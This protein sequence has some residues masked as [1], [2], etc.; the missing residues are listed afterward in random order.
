M[1]YRQLTA[2]Q[3]AQIARSMVE[4]AEADH[5]RLTLQRNAAA[6]LD[7]GA[8]NLDGLDAQLAAVQAQWETATEALAAIPQ[9]EA[10]QAPEPAPEPPTPIE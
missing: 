2:N 5:Y 7:N 1:E 9:P 4:S 3:Q 8:G 6:K 10:V